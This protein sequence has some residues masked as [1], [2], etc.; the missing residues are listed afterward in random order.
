MCA[1]VCVSALFIPFAIRG[2]AFANGQGIVA[3]LPFPV[4]PHSIPVPSKLGGG[5]VNHQNHD[6]PRQ[7]GIFLPCGGVSV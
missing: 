4:N 6:F 3:R 7:N 5:W 2:M 1:C